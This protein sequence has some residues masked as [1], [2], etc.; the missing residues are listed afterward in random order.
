VSRGPCVPPSAP[1]FAPQL[2]PSDSPRRWWGPS[3]A[4]MGP[5]TAP[6]APLA[7]PGSAAE[8]N[9]ALLQSLIRPAERLSPASG[10]STAVPSAQPPETGS[11]E[12]SGAARVGQGRQRRWGEAALGGSH[13]KKINVFPWLQAAIPSA[14]LGVRVSRLQLSAS[15]AASHTAGCLGHPGAREIIRQDP[16]RRRVRTL[17]ARALF[18]RGKERSQ[19]SNC[20]ERWQS[21]AP[22]PSRPRALAFQPC[23]A[24]DATRQ[25]RPH[26][27]P[28]HAA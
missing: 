8:K 16:E 4:A 11:R 22:S 3:R 2:P 25:L 9:S 10:V 7:S 14:G 17:V 19:E 15:P 28:K 26:A 6:L 18:H 12:G 1:R 20:E 24:T 5:P 13:L 21:V 23:P 27:G